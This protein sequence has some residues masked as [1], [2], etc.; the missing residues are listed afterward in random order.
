MGWP[1]ANLKVE[2]TVLRFY[3]GR[4]VVVVIYKSHRVISLQLVNIRL[5]FQGTSVTAM[6]VFVVFFGGEIQHGTFKNLLGKDMEAVAVQLE[7]TLAIR[8]I[9]ASVLQELP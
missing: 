8:R 6:R 9:L 4:V 7:R 1:L 3:G 5:C 2:F